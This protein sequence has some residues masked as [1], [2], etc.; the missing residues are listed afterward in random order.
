V[1]VDTLW[2]DFGRDELEMALREYATRDRRFGRLP[3]DEPAGE[4]ADEDAATIKQ[5]TA[6]P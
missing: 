5:S 4:D 3:Q 6:S 2:P 1:F